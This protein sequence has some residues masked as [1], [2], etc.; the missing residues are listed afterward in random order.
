MA[1][2][3]LCIIDTDYSNDM[4]FQRDMEAIVAS[5]RNEVRNDEFYLTVSHPPSPANL[6]ALGGKYQK[7][8]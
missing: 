6:P 7:S 4:P 1:R 8:I 3:L 5:S 2:Q